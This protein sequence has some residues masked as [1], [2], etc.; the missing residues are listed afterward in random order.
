MTAKH[1]NGSAEM[2]LLRVINGMRYIQ[3]F[4]YCII[5]NLK[6]VENEAVETMGVTLKEFHYNPKFVAE[7]AQ[8][9][10]MFVLIHEA[11]HVAMRHQVREEWRHHERFNIACD[12]YINKAICEEFN[13][14]PNGDAIHIDK[15]AMGI[16]LEFPK[17]DDGKTMGLFSSKVSVAKDTPETIYN[18]LKV[19][20]SKQQGGEQQG[21]GQGQAGNQ[22]GDKSQGGNNNEEEEESKGGQSEGKDGKADKTGGKQNN[23]EGTGKDKG[24]DKG[25]KGGKRK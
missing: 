4:Y 20:E 18:E 25:D 16:G 1:F 22:G 17:Y 9:Q 11:C 8:A 12:L 6:R 5:L 24:K 14:D 23:G 15:D 21:N 13:V 3:P 7:L 10:L 2:K 19:E